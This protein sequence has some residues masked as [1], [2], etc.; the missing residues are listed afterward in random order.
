MLDESLKLP[1]S[2]IKKG[3]KSL[4]SRIGGKSC[5]NVVEEGIL[6]VVFKIETG[7][8]ITFVFVVCFDVHRCFIELV[9]ERHACHG[10]VKKARAARAFWTKRNRIKREC[11]ANQAFLLYI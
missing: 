4:G 6:I 3:T 1:L 7:V 2:Q 5:L 11:S 8:I 10:V 9:K